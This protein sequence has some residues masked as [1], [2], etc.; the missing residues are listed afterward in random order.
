MIKE[1]CGDIGNAEPESVVLNFE[2]CSVCS[3]CGFSVAKAEVFKVVGLFLSRGYMGLQ[4]VIDL[5]P[6]NFSNVRRFLF[7]SVN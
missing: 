6:N 7:E 3:E 5:L 1:F 4:V 2:C